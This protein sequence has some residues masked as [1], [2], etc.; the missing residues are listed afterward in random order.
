ML[1]VAVSDEPGSG[2]D[3][4]AACLDWTLRHVTSAVAHDF[5]LR[6]DDLTAPTRG[7]PRTA[8]AR[9]AAMYLLHVVFGL[10]FGTIG[11]LFGRDRTTVAHACRVVEDHRDDI[12]FDCRLATLE[13]VCRRVPELDRILTESKRG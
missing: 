8:F 3:A 13:R 12:W 11:R 1:S 6:I 10:G 9:Q 4:R 5:G 7:A 2:S